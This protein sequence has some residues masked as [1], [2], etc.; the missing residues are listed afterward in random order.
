VNISGS[1]FLSF[2]HRG[3]GTEGDSAKTGM[4]LQRIISTKKNNACDLLT[5]YIYPKYLSIFFVSR[6]PNY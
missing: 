4:V 2:E 6:L 3:R 5:F 1:K